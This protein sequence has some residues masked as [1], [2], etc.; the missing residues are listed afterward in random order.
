MKRTRREF[1]ADVGGGMLVASVGSS[2]AFD[3]GLVAPAFAADDLKELRFGPLE[4][5]VRLMQE[6][7]PEKLLPLLVEKLHAG[8]ELRTLVAA[9]ALANARTFGGQDYVGFHSFMALAPAHSM[10]EELPPERRPLPVLKVLYRNSDRIQ[11]FGG[12]GRE[13]LHEIE[14]DALPADHGTDALQQATRKGDYDLAERAFAALMKGPM[15]EAYNHLQF[16]VQDEVDVHRVV[17]SWRAWESLDLTGPEHAHSLLRQSVRYCVSAEQSRISRGMP[18]P[19]IR[20]LLPKLLDQYRLLEGAQPSR[21]AEDG[22]VAAMGRTIANADRAEAAE[23]VA[24]A[25]AEGFRP[26]DVAEALCLAANELVLRDPGMPREGASEERPAG[27][28]HGASVGVHAADAANAWRHIAR[29]SSPRN[30]FASV[31]VGAY[32]T[33][34]Q[35][36]RLHE[37]PYPWAE[38]LERATARDP[39]SLLEELDEAIRAKDQGRACAIVQ[40]Y[41]EGGHPAR[42]VLDRLL[43]YAISEDGALH[44]EKYYRTASEEFAAARPAFRWRQLVAL[45]RVTASEF[46][47]A[48]PGFTRARELLKV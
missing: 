30:T 40:R 24:A 36:K 31:I 39:A 5:L 34:G 3:L 18:A 10:A 28:V 14:G 22:W 13:V 33:A 25:L 12:R 35:G 15:G 37:N 47:R 16:S 46:G 41:G 26:E 27:S 7:P 17:L 23:A 8:T 32:H 38:H 45:S 43:S 19:E 11:A 20:A 42:P 9:A 6:T 29:V 1:L 21:A 2:L 44:A 4:P 48:A